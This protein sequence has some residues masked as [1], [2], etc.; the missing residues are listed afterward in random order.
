[1]KPKAHI[2]KRSKVEDN[3]KLNAFDELEHTLEEFV[4]F[5]VYLSTDMPC[6]NLYRNASEV[7]FDAAIK[8]LDCATTEPMW[9][10]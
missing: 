7:S 8:A 10:P 6:F 3:K 5:L 4:C 9:M 2:L 1:M